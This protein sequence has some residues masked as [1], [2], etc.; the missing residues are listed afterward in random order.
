M[1]KHT[2]AILAE[3]VTPE[4]NASHAVREVVDIA[5]EGACIF[6]FVRILK[7]APVFSLSGLEYDV[8]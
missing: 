2:D 7:P 3:A 5:T 4:D 8:A 6:G 1:S